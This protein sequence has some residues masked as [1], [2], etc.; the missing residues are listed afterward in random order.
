MVR[1][2]YAPE[3]L[4]TLVGGGGITTNLRRSRWKLLL[5]PGFLLAQMWV[6]WRLLR[7]ERIDVVHAHWLI[8]QGLIAAML[9]CLPGGKVPLVV[10]SH[11]AD[12][13]ALRGRLLAAMKRRVLRRSSAATVVSSAMSQPI[14]ALGAELEQVR[15]M[16]MG[17][18]LRSRFTHAE[19]AQRSRR[20]IL[21][22][23][24]LVEK[25]GLRHLIAAMPLVLQRAP[26]AFL[27]IVGFGTE[28][29]ALR[30][31]VVGAGLAHKVSFVGAVPQAE[32]PSLYRRAAVFVAPF[33]RAESG[34]QEG[35]GLVVAE[36][37]GCE[38]PVVVGDVPAVHELLGEWPE[39]VVDPQD[40]VALAG[41][42]VGMLDGGPEVVRVAQ[43]LRQGILDRL[44]WQQVADG[45]ARL[46]SGTIESRS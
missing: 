25:K 5:V 44:D 22:V 46:L 32:L 6:A 4:E 11:G 29:A 23:G 7:R 24:R 19:G 30:K 36:A 39:L 3:V 28:E 43:Q 10:T 1:Y 8:P 40:P 45:Y 33:V 38:C 9:Q 42:I 16:P 18:D 20:E 2:R 26:D 35:L 34:D 31:Q 21:F 41:K 37:A 15:V 17:V 14:V 12:L 13:F 27:T